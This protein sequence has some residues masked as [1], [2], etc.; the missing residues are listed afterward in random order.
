MELE[1]QIPYEFLRSFGLQCRCGR[2][3]ERS[4]F[5]PRFCRAGD[6]AAGPCD[7]AGAGEGRAIGYGTAT[8]SK[9]F[10]SRFAGIAQGRGRVRKFRMRESQVADEATTGRVDRR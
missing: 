7:G 10:I 9:I 5:R 1:Q 6:H 3:S 4:R 8:L 2:N